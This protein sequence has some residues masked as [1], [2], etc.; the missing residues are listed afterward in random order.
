MLNDFLA[1]ST[2][3]SIWFSLLASLVTLYGAT[4]FWLKHSKKVISITP[5]K[6]Y[7]TITIVVPVHNE[8]VVIAN[9]TKGI[10][11]L[12]YPASKIELLL[13]ADNCQDKTAAEMRKATDL[14]QYRYRNIQ[15]IERHGSGGK[16]GVLNDA[17]KIA[18]GEYICVYDAD[19]LPEQNALYFLVKKVLENP[20]RYMATFGRNKTRNAKQNFL[21]KCINQEVIVSQRLQHVGVWN[22]FKIGRIPGTNFII[23]TEYVKKI[24][25]W[26][27]GALTEDTEISFR[28]MEDGYLIA[29]A[30]NSEAFEQEPEHLRDYYYQR[31]RWAKGNY[32]VVMNNFKHLFDKSNWRVKLETFYL[33]CTFFWFNL[34]VILS[35]IIFFVDLGCIIARFFNPEIPI[36]FA[37]NS[38]VLLMQLL[39]INW[40]LMIL[41][42]VIQ[43]NLALAT[44]YGQA[45]SDQIWL[46]LVSYFTYSQ[47][48]IAISLQAVCSVIGDKLFRRDG[49]KWVK[50]KRFA[51]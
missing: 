20:Q 12:N 5:L 40:L 15:I 29:L 23:N 31:L 37:M 35:D 22:L 24:G 42:Y 18:Q 11:N 17:L 51:D 36:I 8:E 49:T 30:Y 13:Y 45:T 41:L 3:V 4:C 43:I 2:L 33:T 21:T 7:P 9:T 38:N 27:S 19:A 32:Q 28:I 46:A 6:R 44:Q 50:T 25:G 47:L 14:P 10:L 1:V 34:A 26:Q 39:L 48:F 16:A